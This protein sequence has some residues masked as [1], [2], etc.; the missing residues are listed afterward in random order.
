MAQANYGG[1]NYSFVDKTVEWL[2][3]E[4]ICTKV[5]RDPHISKC[6]GQHFCESCLRFW[7][8]K[9]GK[10][11]CPHCR[12]EGEEFVHFLDK[13]LKRQIDSLTIHCTNKEEGCQWIGEVRS[14]KDHLVSAN[15]C[16]YV[17]VKCTNGCT[18]ST[19]LSIQLQLVSMKR[20]DLDNHLKNDCPLRPYQ[21]EHCGHKNTYH[22][23]TGNEATRILGLHHYAQCLE[24]PLEC[25][26]RCGVKD[27][28][29]KN[30]AK[31]RSH[32]PEEEVKCP[33]K[34]Q[35][36]RPRYKKLLVTTTKRKDLDR[37][38]AEEC[39][40]R[41]YQCEHC[42]LKDTYKAIITKHYGNCPGF[43][44]KCPNRCGRNDIKRKDMEDHRSQ[45]PE[46]KVQCPFEEAGCKKKLV[47]HDLEQHISA[48]QQQHLLMIMGAYKEMKTSYMKIENELH[49]VKEEL[50]QTKA[51]LKQSKDD[52]HKLEATLK[53]QLIIHDNDNEEDYE[54]PKVYVEEEGEEDY[55]ELYVETEGEEDYEVY[56]DD[57]EEEQEE[58][59]EEEYEEPAVEFEEQENDD[60]V[61]DQ[62]FDVRYN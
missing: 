25:P 28:K 40:L 3:C 24:F 34:C 48:T 18:D 10:E 6:C 32:C 11:S 8:T 23:I 33:N 27:I 22:K 30:M 5:L 46:E 47:R 7:F 53:N 17:E 36:L 1:Y 43:P 19:I 52:H 49:Q 38:L 4:T 12:T 60:Y 21:C 51:E 35:R 59:E 26:N 50:S 31:H 39:S 44:L 29:R 57:V 45:C 61:I 14:L 56:Y 55:E 54:E 62:C 16:D 9:H 41:P 13:K 42:T 37:H 2:T 15:G 58:E 20:K